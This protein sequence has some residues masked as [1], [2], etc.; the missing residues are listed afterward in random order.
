MKRS[1]IIEVEYDETNPM[2]DG[3]HRNSFMAF[4]TCKDIERRLFEHPETK[5]FPIKSLEIRA[6]EWGQL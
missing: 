3:E 1:L 4:Q 2:P 6:H 5:S